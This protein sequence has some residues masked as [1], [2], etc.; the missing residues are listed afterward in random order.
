MH[1]QAERACALLFQSRLPRFLWEEAMK[2]TTWL[3]NRTPA[4]ALDG[5]T[6]YEAIHKKKP[7][8]GDIQEFGVAVYVKDI[9]AGKIDARAQVSHFIGYDAES[10]GFRI[11]SGDI[12]SC[13]YPFIYLFIIHI[14]HSFYFAYIHLLLFGYHLNLSC[15][16]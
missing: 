11:L 2:H 7:Y 4:Q 3:Q 14:L 12:H 10:K 5:K 15:S 13:M 16:Q 8:L 1:T 9:H 6:P